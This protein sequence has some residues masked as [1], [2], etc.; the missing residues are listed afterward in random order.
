MSF[1]D[2]I[3][4]VLGYGVIVFTGLA[5]VM[6]AMSEASYRRRQQRR[7]V[8]SAR[9]RPGCLVVRPGAFARTR[10]QNARWQ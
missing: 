6:I 5:L 1:P 10:R 4:M 7:R 2:K 9:R 8:R 3:A